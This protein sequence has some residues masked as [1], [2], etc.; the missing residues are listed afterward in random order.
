VSPSVLDFL[1]LRV[2]SFYKEA[3]MLRDGVMPAP[4]MCILYPTYACNHRCAG[5]D[6]ARLNGGGKTL[7]R[8]ELSHVMDEL[9]SL[10]IKSVEFCGGGEP[11]LHPRLGEAMDRCIQGGVAFGLLTNGTNLTPELRARLVAHGSYCRI[12]VEA[13]SAPV[14]DRYKKPVNR[15]AG[16]DVVLRNI[17][18]LVAARQA[19]RP[20]TRLQISYK[21]SVDMNNYEDVLEAVE[22]ACGLKVD[23][24]QFKCVR[25]VPSEIRDQALIARLREGLRQRRDACPGLRILDNLERSRLTK[26]RCWLSALQL[27]VDAFGDVY[28]CCYYRHRMDRHRLGNLLVRSLKDIWYSQEHW[29]KIGQIE[30]EDC[31][32]YDCRFHR[33]NELMH[34]LVIEDVGQLS[35]I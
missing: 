31:N 4:R 20:A 19:G 29:Q 18:D 27:T 30:L 14:F 34:A 22:V 35:F 13:A 33:Y 26:C 28:I 16:F 7:T 15:D 3:L 10:G 11:T 8:A 5:C 2:L 12:S 1:D 32:K 17:G 25:N 21:Y 23:S 9:L 24:V 6:Y